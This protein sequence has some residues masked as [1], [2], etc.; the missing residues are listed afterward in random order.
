MAGSYAPTLVNTGDVIQVSAINGAWNDGSAVT[1]YCGNGY[2]FILGTCN[3]LAFHG[4]GILATAQY[5]QIICKIGPTYFDCL[6]LDVDGNP[7]AFIVP[8]GVVNQPI[9][10]LCNAILPP[11]FPIGGVVDFCVSITNN[12]LGVW[13]R[14][15][16]YAVSPWGSSGVDWTNGSFTDLAPSWISGIGW[17]QNGQS[18]IHG[19]DCQFCAVS[20]PLPSTVALTHIRM[21]M[22]VIAGVATGSSNARAGQVGHGGIP[23]T[24]ADVSGSN[25]PLL[26]AL[27]VEGDVAF[28]TNILDLE[29]QA[30]TYLGTSDATIV[31]TKLVLQGVG[32]PPSIGV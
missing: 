13:E 30:C 3:K 4:G 25:T 17:E 28:S 20:Q 27:I 21:E 9:E 19:D 2:Q 15:L 1:W 32:V 6:N 11:V 29:A 31:I 26:G 22:V 14:T 8:G 24:S 16:D 5:M 12:A 10:F 18:G 23:I 7:Q